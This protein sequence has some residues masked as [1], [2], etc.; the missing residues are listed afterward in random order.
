MSVCVWRVSKK[1]GKVTSA[2]DKAPQAGVTKV[3]KT[4]LPTTVPTPRSDSVR[5][6]PTTLTNNSGKQ[7]AVAKNVAPATSA[8]ILRSAQMQSSAGSK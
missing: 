7:L 5:K 6:V 4:A 8:L 3:L 2:A 1:W